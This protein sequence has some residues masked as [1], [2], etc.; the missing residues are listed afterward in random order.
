MNVRRKK[1]AIPVSIYAETLGPKTTSI[2]YTTA[3]YV[4]VSPVCRHPSLLSSFEPTSMLL[5]ARSWSSTC[6]WKLKID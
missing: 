4:H 6:P 5:H 1:H 3:T 2:K